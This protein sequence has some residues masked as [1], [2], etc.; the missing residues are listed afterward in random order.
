MFG[1]Q[2]THTVGIEFSDR[3]LGALERIIAVGLILLGFGLLT[4]LVFAPRLGFMIYQGQFQTDR[5]GVISKVLT[6]FVTML[7]IGLVLLRVPLLPF[8]L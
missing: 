2:I 6:S 5:V 1:I 7:L 8:S 3:V 4:P